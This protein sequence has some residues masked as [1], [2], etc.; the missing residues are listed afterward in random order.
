MIT[1]F[2]FFEFKFLLQEE[3][4][5][6]ISFAYRGV[7]DCG[8]KRLNQYSEHETMSYYMLMSMPIRP[9][10]S[11]KTQTVPM[12]IISNTSTENSIK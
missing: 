10:R 2:R 8:A 3:D 1:F 7:N 5:N 4:S 9:A 6:S 12:T 11:P